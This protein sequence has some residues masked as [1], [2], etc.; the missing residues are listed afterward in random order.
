MRVK[1]GVVRHANHKKIIKQAKGFSGRRKSVFKLAKQAVLKS[2]QYK[3]R[4]LRKKKSQFRASWIVKI[5]GAIRQYGIS[6][7]DFIKKL[8]VAKIELNRKMLANLAQNEP[9]SFKT[10]VEKLK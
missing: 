7:S 1:R 6:Y 9:A 5:N 8:S 2:G 10:I 3:Y 4:D